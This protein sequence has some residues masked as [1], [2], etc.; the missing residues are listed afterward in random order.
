MGCKID[1]LHDR[2]RTSFP[3]HRIEH[4]KVDD[5]AW[6]TV[7]DILDEGQNRIG[8]FFGAGTDKE[9]SAAQAFEKAKEQFEE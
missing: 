5:G 3:H 1:K 2:V 7:L 9:E 6:L 4:R 8:R